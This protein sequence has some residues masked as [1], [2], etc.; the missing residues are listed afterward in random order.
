V[1]QPQPDQGFAVRRARLDEVDELLG[2]FESVASEGLWLGSELPVDREE[3]LGRFRDSVGDDP[4]LVEY[5]AVGPEGIVGQLGMEL[6][7]FN[8]AE[9]GM[10]VAR[11]WRGRGVGSALLHAA[12]DWAREAGAHKVSLQLWPHNIAA[13]GL[14]R[15]FGFAEEGRLRRHYRRRNGE[16]WDALVMGLVLDTASP[17]RSAETD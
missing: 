3:K 14:Y 9:L 16:L 13:R 15:K 11:D 7:P 5:V 4:R 12:L 8:V 6:K 1:N 17:G 10:L 2:L